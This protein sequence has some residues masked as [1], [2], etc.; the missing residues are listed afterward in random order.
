MQIGESAA[1]AENVAVQIEAINWMTV[2]GFSIA[3]CA[4]VGQNYGAK[5]YKNITDGYKKDLKIILSIGIFCF[6][7]YFSSDYIMKLFIKTDLNTINMGISYLKILA[8][9]EI[10]LALEIGISGMFN[11]LKN[12]K[13]PTII[14]TLCNALRI[15]LA[16]LVYY[17]GLSRSIFGL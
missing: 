8:F 11:G 6:S 10:F 7:L 15:P 3:L 16:Y 13:I 12:T 17:N 9:S 1:A 2:E 4:L 14:S 5:N